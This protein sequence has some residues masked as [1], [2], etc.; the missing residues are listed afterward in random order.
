MKTTEL[1]EIDTDLI[2]DP[3]TDIRKYQENAKLEELAQ[4]I[5]NVGL[6]NPI[7]VK[8]E[9]NRYEVVTGHRRLLAV[10]IAGIPKI[11]AKITTAPKQTLDVMKIDE[12]VF[13]EDVSAVAIAKYVH[14]VMKE[15]EITTREI[16]DYLGRTQQWVN[17][18]LRLLD[19]DPETKNAIDQGTLAYASALELAK[20]KEPETREALTDAAVTGGANTRV[21]K[22][23]VQDYQ[24]EMDIRERRGL[25]VEVIGELG[26]PPVSRRKCAVCGELKKSEM[27]ITVEVCAKCYPILRD[28]AERY[29]NTTEVDGKQE[30]D[31]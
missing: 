26:P 15:R 18:M 16:G 3:K 9:G 8:R 25:E 27:L 29:R 4:S 7:T 28:S 2:D 5:K 11:T 31:A 6:I 10:R 30:K 24:E 20:I 14:R 21:V 13:R 19:L 22:K 12:N 17:T 23:W 1:L